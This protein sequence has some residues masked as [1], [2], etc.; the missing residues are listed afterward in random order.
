[1]GYANIIEGIGVYNFFSDDY[2]A[3]AKEITNRFKVNLKVCFEDNT[4]EEETPTKRN[5]LIDLGFVET[6]QL[7]VI[8]DFNNYE[9]PTEGVYNQYLL[10]IPVDLVYEDELYLEFNRNGVFRLY[11]LPFSYKWSSFI[12]DLKD[13]VNSA[14]PMQNESILKNINRIRNTYINILQKIECSE[15]VIWTDTYYQTE[16]KYFYS[17]LHNPNIS[18]EDLKYSMTEIDNLQLLDF[19]KVINQEVK[20][21]SGNFSDLQIA[22]IDKF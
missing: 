1:M 3:F 19:M 5:E 4:I 18:I 7:N 16:E 15:I 6:L 8:T 20:I 17:K 12:I 10:S 22:F 2:I 11:F 13:K 21:K 9:N 14:Y